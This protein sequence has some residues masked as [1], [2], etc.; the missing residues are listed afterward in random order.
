MRP[1]SN[2]LLLLKY[3]VP[4]VTQGRNSVSCKQQAGG[5]SGSQKYRCILVHNFTK[6]LPVLKF[7]HRL[8]VRSK[9]PEYSTDLHK[10]SFLIRS[11]YSFVKWNSF[12]SF[13]W[14]CCF[15]LYVILTLLFVFVV[16]CAFVASNKYYIHTYI[17]VHIDCWPMIQL[18]P[19]PSK[20]PII[21]SHKSL[22]WFYFS[23][24]RLPRLSWKR[25]HSTGVLVIHGMSQ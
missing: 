6:E 10:K 21:L 2:K 14:F 20:N 12:Y 24:T 22:E 1:F 3:S 25:R 13:F 4:L 18:M 7:F 16:W 15:V 5:H 9:V 23:G 8:S 19:L 11:L 17:H